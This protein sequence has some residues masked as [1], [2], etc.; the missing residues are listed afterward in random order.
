MKNKRSK[1]DLSLRRKQE[2]LA[3]RLNFDQNIATDISFVIVNGNL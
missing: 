3:K 2:I 1:S